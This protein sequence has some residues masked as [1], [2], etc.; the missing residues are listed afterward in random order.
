MTWISDADYY[1]EIRCLALGL[2]GPNAK[3][4]R[5]N[6]LFEQADLLRKRRQENPERP[7]PDCGKPE[8]PGCEVA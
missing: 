3:S 7:C 1:E 2:E 5:A 4:V 6:L 8:C